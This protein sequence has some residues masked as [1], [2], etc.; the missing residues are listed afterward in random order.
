LD[1]G[2]KLVELLSDEGHTVFEPFSGSGT[3]II[4]CEQLGRKCYAVE[5]EPR[6]V[7]VAVKRW[8]NLTGKAATLEGD[9]RT[10]EEIEAERHGETGK[11]Q[12]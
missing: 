10:F 4:A 3:T 5:I 1:F 9:G 7:D 12:G 11:Q 8:Q 2:V 6:Y